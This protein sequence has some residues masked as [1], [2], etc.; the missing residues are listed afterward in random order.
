M[1][2]ALV[3]SNQISVRSESKLLLIQHSESR[4]SL[5]QFTHVNSESKQS[6]I[7]L[8]L[9]ETSLVPSQPAEL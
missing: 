1:H 9:V 5:I 3:T 7:Q 4:R 8:S 2:V 6:L